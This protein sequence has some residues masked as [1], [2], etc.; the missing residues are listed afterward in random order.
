MRV[1]NGAFTQ[2]RDGRWQAS[3]RIRTRNDLLSNVIGLPPRSAVGPP[4]GRG[5]P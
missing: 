3:L 2:Y 4:P 1:N 5:T